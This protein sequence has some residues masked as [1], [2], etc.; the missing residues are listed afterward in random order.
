MV[1][2]NTERLVGVFLWVLVTDSIMVRN[3]TSH[4]AALGGGGKNADGSTY[5]CACA[6][7]GQGGNA[8]DKHDNCYC[9]MAGDGTDTGSH[10]GS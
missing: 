10:L 9:F 4:N 5:G 3:L 1:A 8:K 7:Y 2:K 6:M